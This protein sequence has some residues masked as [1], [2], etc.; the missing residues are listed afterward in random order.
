MKHL[1][2]TRGISRDQATQL[3]DIAEDMAAVSSGHLPSGFFN[4]CYYLSVGHE[5]LRCRWDRGAAA[6]AETCA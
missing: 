4:Y 2:S 6:V 5:F 3:L 1:L